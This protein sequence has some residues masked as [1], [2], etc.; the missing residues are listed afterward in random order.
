[1]ISVL[2]GQVQ[3]SC[4]HLKIRLGLIVSSISLSLMYCFF[5]P[6]RHCMVWESVRESV[7]K[8]VRESIRKSVRESVRKSV[9]ESVRKSVRELVRGLSHLAFMLNVHAI[10]EPSLDEAV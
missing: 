4:A 9:R 8:S 10:R 2:L 3:C 6:H 5:E 1:M 7:R